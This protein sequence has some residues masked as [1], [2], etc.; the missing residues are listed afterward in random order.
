MSVA[1]EAHHLE[2]RQCGDRGGTE[3]R[4]VHSEDGQDRVGERG[5]DHRAQEADRGQP[6]VPAADPLRRASQ[7]PDPSEEGGRGR[8]DGDGVVDGEGR[9][10]RH[11]VAP[12]GGDG[13]L[14]HP[15]GGPGEGQEEPGEGVEP[16]DDPR[17]PAIRLLDRVLH[18]VEGEGSEA[19]P[20]E[21]REAL[22]PECGFRPCGEVPDHLAERPEGAQDPQ[23]DQRK[24]TAVPR[25]AEPEGDCDG[26]GGDAGCER[27]QGVRVHGSEL[28]R[29]GNRRDGEAP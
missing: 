10:G 20:A 12:G 5:G 13:A 24:D 23:R 29:G 14:D 26:R 21:R 27:D 19:H 28:L 18:H 22:E 15:R 16:A 4:H 3:P 7:V 1:E 8:G 6:P 25:R 2:R 17:D 9:A 11:P